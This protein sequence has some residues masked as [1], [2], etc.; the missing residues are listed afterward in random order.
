MMSLG[1]GNVP[2]AHGRAV[3]TRDTVADRIIAARIAMAEGTVGPALSAAVELAT[4]L[5]ERAFASAVCQALSAHQLS[6]FAREVL[7]RGESVWM[8][9]RSG[10]SLQAA[11]SWD[12]YGMDQDP[13]GWRYRMTFGGPNTSGR[14]VLESGQWVVHVRIGSTRET[15]WR[16]VSP[17]SRIVSTRQILD[18]LESKFADEVSGPVGAVLPVPKESEQLATDINAMRGNVVVGETMAGGWG[19]GD[20]S[21]ARRDWQPVRVGSEVPSSN[22]EL[23]RDVQAAVLAAAGVPPELATGGG[24]S[25]ADSREGWRRFLHSTIAP[26]GVLLSS[27][28][29]RVG[30]PDALGFDS[31]FASDLQGRARAF[32][33]LVTAG[34]EPASAARV[35]GFEDLMMAARPQG[36]EDGEA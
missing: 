3:E 1:I 11:Q 27:E 28:L 26:V 20:G 9:P 34:A 10:G 31:L 29:R 18:L 13:A 21:A 32:G 35:C 8:R 22:V 2:F 15:P 17:L 5:W 30:L 16:G 12:I 33:S 4:G 6:V 36:G 25:G 24:H 23:R 7:T 19:S 14:T